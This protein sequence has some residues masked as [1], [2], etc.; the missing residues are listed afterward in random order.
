MIGFPV[1]VF[2]P[3]FKNNLPCQDTGTGEAAAGTQTASKA[4]AESCAAALL[5]T[6]FRRRQSLVKACYLL[7]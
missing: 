4:A 6:V 3:L 1:S 5:D 2:I 7:K